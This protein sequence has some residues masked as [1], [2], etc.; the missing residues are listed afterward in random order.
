[1]FRCTG[2]ARGKYIW[3]VVLIKIRNF[4][5]GTDNDTH[6]ISENGK[7]TARMV[8]QSNTGAAGVDILQLHMQKRSILKFCI[9]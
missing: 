5:Y 7:I 6:L 3:T 8:S 9:I 4:L 2:Y 1:M